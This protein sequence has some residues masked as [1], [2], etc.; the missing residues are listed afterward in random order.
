MDNNKIYIPTNI[1][2]E[3]IIFQGYSTKELGKTLIFSAFLCIIWGIVYLFTNSTVQLMF[4]V[5]ASIVAGVYIF[6]KDTTNQCIVDYIKY[7]IKYSC[8]QRIYKYNNEIEKEE[9]Y[10]VRKYQ[11]NVISE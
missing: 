1:Q 3:T 7:I 11:D 5:M 4:E 2:T 10:L 8:T 9:A 6:V